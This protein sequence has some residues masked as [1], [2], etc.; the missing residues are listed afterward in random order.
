MAKLALI[1]DDEEPLR[2]IIRESLRLL[3]IDSV[4]AADG[5]SA[6]DLAQSMNNLDLIILDMNMPN[7]SG[8][9]TYTLLQ[10]KFASCPVIFTSGY[11]M[12][13]IVDKLKPVGSSLFLRKPFTIS[14]FQ[15]AVKNILKLS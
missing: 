3:K 15:E 10:Q 6:F 12:Q 4:E 14:A 7:I 1:V 13:D 9:K 2:E 5:N 8:E 11:D